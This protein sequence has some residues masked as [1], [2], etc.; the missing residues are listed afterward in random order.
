MHFD[1]E[2]YE[3]QILQIYK[4][5]LPIKLNDLLKKIMPTFVNEN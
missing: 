2:I 3:I 4:Q 5:G 1:I